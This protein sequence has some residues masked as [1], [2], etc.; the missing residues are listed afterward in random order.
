MTTPEA[1]MVH[2]AMVD[3][4]T[5]YHR[6]AR[7]HFAEREDALYSGKKIAVTVE[8]G[9]REA[10]RTIDVD[11]HVYR[12]LGKGEL[13]THFYREVRYATFGAL[14]DLGLTLPV[15]RIATRGPK[16]LQRKVVEEPV[17]AWRV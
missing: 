4:V 8:V 12:S 7:V 17:R 6:H 15:F 10:T 16:R 3:L 2:E 11:V 9:N 14:R 1:E 13:L 5:S